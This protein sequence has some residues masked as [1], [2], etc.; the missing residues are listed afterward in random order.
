VVTPSYALHLVEWAAARGID[1]AASSSVRRVL[2]AGEPGGGEPAMR[3]SSKAGLGREGDRG[4][5]HRRHRR[6][7]L[8]RMRVSGRHAFQRRGFVHVELIDPETGADAGR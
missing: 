8:G 4:D 1:L 3:R 7:A 5:G 2:V 6:L